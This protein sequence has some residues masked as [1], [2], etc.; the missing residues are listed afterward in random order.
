MP[1]FEELAAKDAA[2][3]AL[4]EENDVLRAKMAALAEMAFGGSERRGAQGRDGEGG[5]GDLDDGCS[6]GGEDGE[7]PWGRPRAAAPMGS[8]PMGPPAT[9]EVRD[10]AGASGAPRPAMAGAATTISR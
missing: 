3:A 7:E 1:A 8:G 10:G 2:L 4:H 6:G 5:L 9:S